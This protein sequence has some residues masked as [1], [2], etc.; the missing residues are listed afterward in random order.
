MCVGDKR[1]SA[2]D[3]PLVHDKNKSGAYPPSL[4]AHSRRVSP[5]PCAQSTQRSS[6]ADRSNKEKT[7]HGLAAF[8]CRSLD[9]P[10][11]VRYSHDHETHL[12]VRFE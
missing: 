8:S 1:V 3:P 5:P 2:H 12:L 6:S 11:N 7:P 4:P 9:S 10:L